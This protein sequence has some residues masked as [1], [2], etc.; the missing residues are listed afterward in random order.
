MAERTMVECHGIDL[1]KFETEGAELAGHLLRVG[2][3][4]IDDKET[5]GQTKV[6]PG[7]LIITEDGVAFKFLLTYQLQQ[8]IRAKYIGHYFVIRYTGG[9]QLK[10]GQSAMQLFDVSR[11]TGRELDDN[12][13]AAKLE[14]VGIFQATSDDIPF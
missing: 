5:P 11:S 14:D 8:K 4:Q 9:K 3:A 10:A 7:A 2:D 12:A 13:I 6:V 1:C